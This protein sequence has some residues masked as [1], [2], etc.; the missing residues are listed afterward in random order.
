[1]KFYTAWDR[2]EKV[3]VE[4]P[5]SPT[6]TEQSGW[7]PPGKQIERFMRAGVRL[8]AYRKAAY[9]F[10]PGTEPDEGFYDPTRIQGF[11]LA[12]ASSIYSQ[13]MERLNAQ[14][15]SALQKQQELATQ[16]PIRPEE[17]SETVS[18]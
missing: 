11:D 9:D 1:M 16:T 18:K 12:D 10:P 17:P 15:A 4:G 6:K 13:T 14:R 8:D 3:I 7:L 2:P 5:F